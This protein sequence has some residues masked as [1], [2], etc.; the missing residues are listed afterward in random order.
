[1]AMSQGKYLMM[2]A[3]ST[4]DVADDGGDPYAVPLQILPPKTM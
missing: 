3:T 1:M 4:P 2:R